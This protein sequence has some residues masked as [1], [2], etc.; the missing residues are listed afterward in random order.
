MSSIFC[1]VCMHDSQYEADFNAGIKQ[2]LVTATSATASHCEMECSTLNMQLESLHTLNF[3]QNAL[4]DT[5]ST[6]TQHGVLTC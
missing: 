3:P 1:A 2:I 6:L 5:K 4:V